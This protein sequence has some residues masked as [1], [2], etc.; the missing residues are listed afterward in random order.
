MRAILLLSF[1]LVLPAWA[2][3]PQPESWREGFGRIYLVRSPQPEIDLSGDVLVNNRTVARLERGRYTSLDAKPGR[4]V[5]T[6]KQGSSA[7][8]EFQPFA[9]EVRPNRAYILQLDLAEKKDAAKAPAKPVGFFGRVFGSTG[10]P[11]AYLGQW[12]GSESNGERPAP[13]KAPLGAS[14][15]APAI[16]LFE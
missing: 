9:F 10:A 4:Y 11:A 1:F 5:V 12:R 7:D 6:F 2:Q 13:V 16:L 15:V 3:S 14:F 8:S